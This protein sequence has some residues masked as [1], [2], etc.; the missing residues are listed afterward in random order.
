[1]SASDQIRVG[2]A[3][4]VEVKERKDRVD[5]AMHATRAAVKEGILPSGGVALLRAC[6]VFKKARTH[7]RRPVSRLSARRSPLQHARSRPMPWSHQT[8]ADPMTKIFGEFEASL[9]KCP[10]RA[11][12]EVHRLT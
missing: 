4:E 3:T 7:T 1:M 11:I 12:V 5:D 9:N 2:G 10:P 6:E 8:V